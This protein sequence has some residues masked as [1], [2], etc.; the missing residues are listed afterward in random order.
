EVEAKQMTLQAVTAEIADVIEERSN[1]GKDYGV[2]LIPE[3]LIEFIPEMK[4]LI[5]E[6]NT[7]LAEG[8]DEKALSSK[9][10]ATFDFLPKE[11][12]QQLLFDRDP[13]GNVQVSH[14]QTDLLF[15]TTVKEELKRR[16]SFK[17]KFSPVHH[18][19]GYEGRAGLPTNF[20]A[21]YCYA[22]GH[23]A[24]LLIR[25]GRTGYMS[26]VRHLSTPPEKWDL[27]GIPITSLMNI[28]IRKGKEKPVI[29]KALVD[30]EGTPFKTFARNR[31]KWRTE[32]HYAYPGPIQFDGDPTITNQIPK[33]LF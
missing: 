4:A 9:A 30:L 24:A 5:G 14:I 23:V 1:Q 11:I 17:G 13:H 3:G 20:D 19:F 22:L 7:L 33:S 31:P 27:C 12:A 26:A 6:L 21:T 29:R 25:D 32:D 10:K 16:S 18:F 28:E 8:K 2:I 15:S